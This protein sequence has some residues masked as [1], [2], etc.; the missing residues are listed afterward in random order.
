MRKHGTDKVGDGI[1]LD[2]MNMY[3]AKG[4]AERSKAFHN[5]LHGICSWFVGH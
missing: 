5:A 3:L 4:R 1:T 2:Q